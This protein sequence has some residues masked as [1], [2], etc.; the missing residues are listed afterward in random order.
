MGEMVEES[1]AEALSTITDRAETLYSHGSK[2]ERNLAKSIQIQVRNYLDFR[3]LDWKD[4]DSQL[5]GE[6]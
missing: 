4:V 6:K 5:E 2:R 3:G 1:V